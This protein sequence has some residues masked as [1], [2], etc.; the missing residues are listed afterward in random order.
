MSIKLCI[1]FI[2]ILGSEWGNLLI[3][4][5]GLIKIEVYRT[6]RRR[7]HDGPV[8]QLEYIRNKGEIWSISLDGWLRAWEYRLID[9][10]DPPDDDRV[11]Q[12]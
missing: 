4:E 9:E 11:V 5:A 6:M 7:C 10:A 3:W 12:V 1:F 8:M 2:N